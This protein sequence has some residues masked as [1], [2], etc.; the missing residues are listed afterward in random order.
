MVVFAA[1]DSVVCLTH[2]PIHPLPF[3][4]PN[5]AFQGVRVGVSSVFLAGPLVR[6]EGGEER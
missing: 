4:H 6:Q 5:H 2:P 3:L 1:I